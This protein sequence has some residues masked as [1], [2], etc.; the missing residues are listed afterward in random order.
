MPGVHVRP[1]LYLKAAALQCIHAAMSLGL[2]LDLKLP[3]VVKY[4][5]NVTHHVLDVCVFSCSWQ[6]AADAVLPI[7]EEVDVCTH[8]RAGGHEL[9]RIAVH[10]IG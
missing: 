5:S 8:A 9:R 1:E 6:Q 10:S 7:F 4:S 3:M 2:R